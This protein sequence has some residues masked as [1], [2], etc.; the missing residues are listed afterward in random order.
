MPNARHRLRTGLTN[1][2]RLQNGEQIKAR[3]QTI[4]EPNSDNLLEVTLAA[5]EAVE[6]LA[7]S[8]GDIRDA[9]VSWRD[10]ENLGLVTIRDI[11]DDIQNN[12]TEQRVTA[13]EYDFIIP[14]STQVITGG[15][16]VG[17]VT[18]AQTLKDGNYYQ[19]PEVSG[20]PGFDIRFNFTNVKSIAGFVSMIR[21]TGSTTHDVTL[22][23]LNYSTV[24]QDAFLVIPHTATLDAYRTVLIPDDA[25]YIN[26]SRQAQMTLYHD[27]V[28]DPL[29]NIYIDYIALIGKAI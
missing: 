5:K 23:I 2:P 6:V 7:G 8:R 4:P 26:S 25:N 11:N 12:N 21:Y 18:D 3:V 28:G 22:R 29:H 24:D 16:P 13:L 1:D 20:T 15:T 9:S 14:A 17:S 27:S 19:V 10:L